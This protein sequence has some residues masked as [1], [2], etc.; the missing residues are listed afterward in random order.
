MQSCSD[1]RSHG[2]LRSFV[3]RVVVVV[4]VGVGAEAL[5]LDHCTL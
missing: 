5:S 3:V 1:L 2:Q 4:V